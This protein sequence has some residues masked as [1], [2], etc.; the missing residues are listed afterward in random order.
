M[1][2]TFT[3]TI[4]YFETDMNYKAKLPVLFQQLQNAA[5]SH[6]EKA[7][8]R[9]DSLIQSGQGW[10][11]N[12][13]D[14]QV[15]RY[16]EYKETI[17][18][19]TWS[20]SIKG[21]KAKR[22][23]LVYANGEK[24]ISASSIWVFV[25]SI[26]MKIIK[27]PEEMERHYTSEPEVALNENLDQWRANRHPVAEFQNRISTRRSDCDFMGHVNNTVYIDFLE[28]AVSREIGNS[29][30]IS[31][32]KIQYLKELNPSRLW[33]DIGFQRFEDRYLFAISDDQDLN[34]AGEVVL[35]DF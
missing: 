3:H 2:I 21:V 12:K 4:N 18:I 24:L 19:I 20:R 26:R 34:A 33:V 14:M 31:E 8:Y 15:F 6:A 13:M 32:V 22:E 25:D 5:V 9:M 28:T 35:K 10:V 11:L 17:E 7:G 16:P 23:F 29:I 30:R 27:A 1:K